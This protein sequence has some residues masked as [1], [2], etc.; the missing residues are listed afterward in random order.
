MPILANQLTE[1]S[2]PD[3]P[4]LARA[5]R[6]DYDSARMSFRRISILGIGLLG[7]SLARAIKRG[8]SSCQVVGYAHRPATLEAA[9]GQG[10]VD[11]GYADPAAAVRGADVVVLCTP[12]GVFPDLL[13]AITPALDQAA[14]ITDVGST[15]RS[16]CGLAD[17]LPSPGRFVGSHPMAGSEKRGLEHADAD[18]YKNAL[19]ILTPTATTDLTTIEK[20]ESLWHLVGM[21]TAQMTPEDHD[22]RVALASHLPHALA[23]A[24]MTLQT[25]ASL[26]VAGKGLTDTTRIAAGDPAMWRDILIDNRDNLITGLTALEKRLA[27]LR[28]MLSANEGPTLHRWLTDAAELRAKLGQGR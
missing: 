12:V 4:E 24:L 19:C 16:I 5:T 15:K 8:A 21:R 6:T 28:T 13:A 14:V 3:D 7:A 20:V 10:V 25:P 17:S 1:V 23:A 11:E 27:E 2:R 18:L 26:A 22:E 9:L